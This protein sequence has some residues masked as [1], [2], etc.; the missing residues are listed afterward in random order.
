VVSRSKRRVLAVV[1]VLLFGVVGGMAGLYLSAAIDPVYEFKAKLLI[2]DS[3]GDPNVTEREA[4]S[5]TLLGTE[6]LSLIRSAVVLNDVI[7]ELGLQ[8][9]AADLRRRVRVTPDQR[10]AG[11][12][13]VS[14][15]AATEAEAI[16]TGHAIVTSIRERAEPVP[17]RSLE[18][19]ASSRR[20]LENRIGLLERRTSG[21]EARLPQVEGS[22]AA[23]VRAEIASL[24]DA[25]VR[26]DERY[27]ALVFAV[28]TN[29]GSIQ[30]LDEGTASSLRANRRIDLILGIA[31]GALLGAAAL[32]AHR[33]WR[34]RATRRSEESSAD[35]WAWELTMLPHEGETTRTS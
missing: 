30:S 32:A 29:A 11:V 17:T 25:I 10:G 5:G 14:V 3:R 6:Y 22:N 16:D 15:F 20:R 13:N 33:A 8:T 26:A 34:V 4:E 1:V 27:R 35:P 12:L 2:G 7:H 18:D 28:D 9:S 23:R 21:L 19:V 24:S 31:V